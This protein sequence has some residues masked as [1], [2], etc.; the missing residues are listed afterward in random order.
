MGHQVR[1]I[2]RLECYLTCACNKIEAACR[3]FHI[4]IDRRVRLATRVHEQTECGRTEG[5][6]HAPKATLRLRTVSRRARTGM[7]ALSCAYNLEMTTTPIESPARPNVPAEQTSPLFPMAACMPAERLRKARHP[8]PGH[9]RPGV[10]SYC[11]FM[12]IVFAC[13]ILVDVWS[14][15]SLSATVSADVVGP[16]SVIVWVLTLLGG[17]GIG[18]IAKIGDAVCR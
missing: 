13:I 3:K 1:H 7:T 6:R 8:R 15:Q 9:R 2:G 5:L 10:S 12:M 4:V 18:P 11:I 14:D 17:L 16:V